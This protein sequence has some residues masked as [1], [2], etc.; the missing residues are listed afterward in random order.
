V[1]PAVRS[2]DDELM[3][4]YED[5]ELCPVHRLARLADPLIVV[6]GVPGINHGQ[7]SVPE[8]EPAVTGV[9]ELNAVG[10]AHDVQVRLKRG[11]S[12]P[13]QGAFANLQQNDSIN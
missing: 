9:I 1:I 12:V 7:D 3:A 13:A 6:T 2:I 11:P 4:D 5:R 8:L 10:I